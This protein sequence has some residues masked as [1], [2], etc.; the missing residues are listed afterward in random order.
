[1]GG[2]SYDDNDDVKLKGGTDDTII[3]NVGDRLKVDAE[4]TANFANT[5]I[6]DPQTGAES[7]VAP[8]GVLHIAALV[9][10]V[11]DNFVEGRLLLARQWN[12]DTV[13]SGYQQVI[14]G[15][16]QLH[17]GTT[18]NSEFAIETVRIARFI[19]GTFNLSHQAI[20]LPNVNATDVKR[21]WGCYDPAAG[22]N[23]GVLWCNE[24]GN[25][26]VTRYKNGIAIETVSEGSFNGPNTLVKNDN[27]HIYECMYNAGKIFFLQDRK[28]IHTM[29]SPASAAYGTPHLK[30]GVKIAN[31]N[32]NTT[33]NRIVSRG[34]S[35]GRLGG[36]EVIPSTAYFDAGGSY[37]VK[38]TPGRLIRIVIGDKGT[39]AASITLYD[40]IDNTGTIIAAVDTDEI[41]NDLVYDVEFDNGLFIE[42][43]GT[44]VKMTVV[45]E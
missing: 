18:A 8:N 28:L 24:D 36:A 45:Y 40:G 27:I 1:M 38:N 14:D 35:I 9:R 19:T 43:S 4:I 25:W 41:N 20:A 15:E 17:T 44:G 22:T 39:A 5:T 32:G 33:D 13:G 7:I 11:G 21:E 34:L 29:G 10:L 37:L 6:I 26:S 2:I 42:I 23:N 12:L 30:C 31:K 16:L 3:G